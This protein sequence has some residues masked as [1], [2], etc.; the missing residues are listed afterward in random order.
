MWDMNKEAEVN[1]KRLIGLRPV[2]IT[3]H[4]CGICGKWI[5]KPRTLW[6]FGGILLRTDEWG[7]CDVC[8]AKQGGGE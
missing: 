7:P 2:T 5:N 3:G 6:R 1:W 4:H 8:G